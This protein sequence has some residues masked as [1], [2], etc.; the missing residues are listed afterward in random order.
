MN[1]YQLQTLKKFLNRVEEMAREG[2]PGAI[3]CRRKI[4]MK[5]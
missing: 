4:N 5:R 2:S 3:C 1:V